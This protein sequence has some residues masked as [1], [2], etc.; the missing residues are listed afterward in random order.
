MVWLVLKIEKMKEDFTMG[1]RVKFFLCIF[2]LCSMESAMAVKR[3]HSK[4]ERKIMN[5]S[6]NDIVN[7][8]EKE[9]KDQFGLMC[10]SLGGDGL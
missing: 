8:F 3:E 5:Q 4:E 6:V 7:I 2:L 9:M 1:I 10:T